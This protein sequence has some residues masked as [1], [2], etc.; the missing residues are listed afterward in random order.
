MYQC[1]L[2]TQNAPFHIVQWLFPSNTGCGERLKHFQQIGHAD[3][4]LKERAHHF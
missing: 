3:V 1:H 2:V 4:T